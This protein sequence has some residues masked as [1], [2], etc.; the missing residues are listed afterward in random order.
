MEFRFED[1]T[2]NVIP[3]SLLTLS[4]IYYFLEQLTPAEFQIFLVN[5]IKDYSAVLIVVFLFAFYLCG[6]IVDALASWGEHYIIY[7][8]LGTP[9]YKLFKE[10]GNR[11]TFHLSAEVLQNLDRQYKIYDKKIISS[12][13]KRLTKNQASELFKFASIFSERCSD[14]LTKQ[15]LKEYYYSYIFS[16]NIFFSV[17]FSSII[18]IVASYDHLSFFALLSLIML[19]VL[20]FIRR[21]DKSYYY[22]RQIL[23]ACTKIVEISNSQAVSR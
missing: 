15:K 10:K 22:S 1:I 4:L 8:T 13:I 5:Y 12:D 18:L 3:G 7:K 16:R 11:I 20:L 23:I 14:D 9:A 2:K 21:R 6:Y 19:N 17:F